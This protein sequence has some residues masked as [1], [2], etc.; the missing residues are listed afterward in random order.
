MLYGVDLEG[1]RS[2]SIT[3]YMSPLFGGRCRPTSEHRPLL[4]LFAWL[5]LGGIMMVGGRAACSSARWEPVGLSHALGSLA[6]TMS[7]PRT[8]AV[9]A[10]QV[11]CPMGLTGPTEVEHSLCI[12][13]GSVHNC[14]FKA[15]QEACRTGS[16]SPGP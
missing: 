16:R 7:I 4:T 15:Y 5:V 9:P 8:P 1:T 2:S 6:C 10:V 12:S 11:S 14:S 13:C 3:E